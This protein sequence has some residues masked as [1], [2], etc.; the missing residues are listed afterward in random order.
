MSQKHE[1]N[2]TAM[3]FTSSGTKLIKIKEGPNGLQLICAATVPVLLGSSRQVQEESWKDAAQK[4]LASEKLE[5]ETLFLSFNDPQMSFS[6]FILPKIPQKEITETLKWKMKDDLPYPVEEAVLDYCLFEVENNEKTKQYSALITALPRNV[7]DPFYRFLPIHNT[8]TVIPVFVPFT[9]DSL[10]KAF[11]FSKQNLVIIID[12]G[13]SFTEIAFYTDRKLSFLRK[14]TFG[15]L[16]LSQTMTNPLISEQGPVAL[17]LDEADKIKREENILD[18]SS[19]KIVAGKIEVAKLFALIRPELEELCL[20]ITRSLD[21]YTQGHEHLEAQIYLTG[22]GS[23][24]KGLDKFIEQNVGVP[25]HSIQLN[26]DLVVSDQLK[27][28]DLNSYYR[29]ISIVL[30]RKDRESVSMLKSLNKSAEHMAH[31]V[32]YLQAAVTA[33]VILIILSG[34][35]I[36]RYLDVSQKTADLRRQTSNLKFGFSEAQKINSVELQINQGAILAS[37][38]LEKEPYWEEVFRELSYMFPDHVILTQF[39]Y[40]GGSY[41]LTGKILAG[42]RETSISKLLTAMEGPIFK[43]VSLVN[44]QQGNDFISFVIRARST[45]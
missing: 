3:E 18:F 10:A 7:I 21:Y 25:V 13:H 44:T 36:W 19:Q 40:E 24:L 15:S 31:S 8:E 27:N 34:G 5:N 20:E 43:K 45:K 16:N 29:L 4:L 23:H 9:I 11:S 6:Q 2:F 33:L 42:D 32:S 41:R 26:Q 12:I 39:I 35:M 17:T 22:G 38:I 1:K 30:D 28:A 37:A 14:I